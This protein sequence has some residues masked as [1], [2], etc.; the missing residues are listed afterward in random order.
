[1]TPRRARTAV[2]WPG[3]HTG[4]QKLISSCP[5]YLSHRN[6]N[7]IEPLNPHPVPDYPW[8][9]VATDLFQWDEKD[10]LVLDDYYSRYFEMSYLDS[11]TS[12]SVIKQMKSIFSRFGIPEKVVSDNGPQYSSSEF[13]KF[14]SD[15][16]FKHTTSSPKYPQSNGLAERSVQTIKRIFQKCKGNKTDPHLGILEYRNSPPPP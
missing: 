5:E 7:P 3:L 9:V 2:F 16:G 15:Y 1:M 6:S 4:I 13:T 14:A 12:K 10:Y 11:T 8:Q